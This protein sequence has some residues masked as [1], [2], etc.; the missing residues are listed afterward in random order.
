MSEP[1]PAPLLAIV[2]DPSAPQCVDDVCVVPVAVEAEP[3]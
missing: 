3:A 1:D 2:G